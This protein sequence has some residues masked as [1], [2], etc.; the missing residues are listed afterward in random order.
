MTNRL[1]SSSPRRLACENCGTEFSCSLSGP[2]WCAD[3]DFRLPMPA[4]DGGDCLCPD[5]LRKLA[6]QRR[7]RG[8][9]VTRRWNVGAVLLDMDGTLL[10]T[11]KVYFDSLIAALNSLGLPTTSFRCAM[12]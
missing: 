9:F 6:A 1:E 4:R 7:K 10:D 11:E 5:C 12:P 8:S 2:C 3:E